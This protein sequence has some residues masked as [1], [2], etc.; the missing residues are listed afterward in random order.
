MAEERAD[1]VSKS[2]ELSRQGGRHLE[3][4][5]DSLLGG[6]SASESSDAAI[7]THRT[8]RACSPPREPAAEPAAVSSSD[9]D[10][11]RGASLKRKQRTPPGDSIDSEETSRTTE[12]LAKTVAITDGGVKS[13]LRS[14]Q[15][16][17]GDLLECMQESAFCHTSGCSGMDVDYTSIATSR[18]TLTPVASNC[19]CRKEAMSKC[20]SVART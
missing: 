7:P 13:A 4:R 11:S 17:L 5:G 10:D 8:R 18:G 1:V 12:T 16:H 3:D 15:R 2:K 6:S 20:N 9:A 19:L 14:V